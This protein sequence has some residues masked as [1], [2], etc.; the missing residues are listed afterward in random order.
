MAGKKRVTAGKGKGKGKAS[1]PNQHGVPG[2][3]R[4]MLAEALPTH[5]DIPERPL[6]RRMTG[7]Q[8]PIEAASSKQKI[9][10]NA[11]P[12]EDDEDI[13]FEDVLDRGQEDSDASIDPPKLQQTAYRSDDESGGSDAE[14]DPLDFDINLDA[15]E[16]KGDLELT[17]TSRPTPKQQ[18]TPRRKVV[19]KAD[20]SLRLEIHKMHLL[21][22]LSYLS[23]RNGWC[24]D[25]A[26]H[27]SLKP[28]LDKKMLQFLRPKSDLSQ[29]GQTESL[30]RGVEM[31]STMWRKKF[32]ITARGMRRALWAENPEDIQNVSSLSF[33]LDAF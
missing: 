10:E 32:A 16:P 1:A 8:K 22:L 5:Q 28:L 25:S 15:D 6:K 14:W 27:K 11:T 19:T 9:T 7:R 30:K 13:E 3:Y 4:E 18:N 26:V 12:D 23:R 20:R 29:F 33:R 21:C 2:V 24:N 31:V 17:L